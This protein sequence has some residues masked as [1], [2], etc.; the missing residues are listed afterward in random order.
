M[1]LRLRLAIV[2]GSLGIARLLAQK[3]DE[4]QVK[5]AF[6]SNFAGFVEW[7][8]EVFKGPA[9][10]LSICVLGRNPFGR[11][12]EAMTEGKTVGGRS[13]AVRQVSGASQ[14]GGCHIV[15]VSSSERLRFRSIL[16]SFKAASVLSVGDANDFVAEGGVI[17]LRLESGKVQ[18]EIS[19]GAAK[20]KNLRI[21]SRLLSLA[22]NVK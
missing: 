5:A 13:F 15:F 2:L 8:P 10:P 12:L 22:R 6:V 16:E 4:Y 11:S 20:E 9:D 7:P 17:N 19:V 14:A 21:S 1:A 3:M 18:I